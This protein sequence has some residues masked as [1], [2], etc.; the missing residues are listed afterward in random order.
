LL[1]KI[2]YF[3][4]NSLTNQADKM[5]T[6]LTIFLVITAIFLS[7]LLYLNIK[8]PIE[9]GKIK[10]ERHEA[11]IAKLEDI[12]TSQEV[13]RDITGEFAHNFDTLFQVLK[14]DSVTIEKV[15]GDPDD[16]T[17]TEFIRK[18]IRVSAMDS[19]ANLGIPTLD[20]LDKLPYNTSKSFSIDAD[21]MTY[22]STLVNVCQVG[23][24]WKDF[25]G[26]YGS[27]KYAKYDNSYDPNN[28]VKF[29][30]MD[31]PNLSGNW[32]R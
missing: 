28:M 31:S 18:Y 10:N 5:K 12:R 26:E 29:G 25:M 17:G 23:T 4:F 15:L 2:I 11:V 30:S 16:P 13:Y 7:Y 20:G 1:L 14:T 21:T 19:L 6:I 9:F 22:Q 8:E 24:R 32:G 3:T 27:A